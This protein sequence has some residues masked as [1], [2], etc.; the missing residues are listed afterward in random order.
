MKERKDNFFAL[1]LG[2][3]T[4]KNL[5]KKILHSYTPHSYTIAP[6]RKGKRGR[7]KINQSLP[8]IILITIHSAHIKHLS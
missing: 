2:S 1:L 8:K 5:M 3:S 6:K 7:K 4:N